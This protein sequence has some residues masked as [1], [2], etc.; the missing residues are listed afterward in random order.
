MGDSPKWRKWKM[1]IIHYYDR[2][3]E[4]NNTR[5]PS[6]YVVTFQQK[7]AQCL[8]LTLN[9]ISGFL[10]SW[11]PPQTPF[12]FSPTGPSIMVRR[13]TLCGQLRDMIPKTMIERHLSERDI[14]SNKDLR[15]LQARGTELGVWIGKEEAIS[16]VRQEQISLHGRKESRN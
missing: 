11:H 1:K 16:R 7:C 4:Q 3:H 8:L 14:K 6:V 15:C 2:E 9:P 5:P 12:C 13:H 10:S